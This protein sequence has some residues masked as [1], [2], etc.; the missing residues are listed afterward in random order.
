ME[1][2]KSHPSNFQSCAM[3][4]NPETTFEVGP[5]LSYRWFGHESYERSWGADARMFRS[6][7]KE[8]GAR[9]IDSAR[10]SIYV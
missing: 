1:F 10:R 6:I 5:S 7:G 9:P 3:W 2:G 8:L 4:G